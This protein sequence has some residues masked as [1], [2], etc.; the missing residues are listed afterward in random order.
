MTNSKCSLI[1]EKYPTLNAQNPFP[2]IP[3]MDNDALFSSQG[4]TLKETREQ[5]LSKKH[6]SDLDLTE[7]CKR[8]FVWLHQ[9]LY[10]VFENDGYFEFHKASKRGNNI[11][12]YQL[13][14]RIKSAEKFF[15]SPEFEY[16]LLREEQRNGFRKPT[17]V[18]NVLFV[19]LTHDTKTFL[20]DRHKAWISVE[21]YYNNFITA[22][23]KRHGK[24]WVLKSV[25]ST[26]KGYPHIHLL[27]I[28]ENSFEVF[29]HV[30]KENKESW[31]VKKK[32]KISELWYRGFIDVQ[33]PTSVSAVRRYITKD[34]L[35][36]YFNGIQTTQGEL[37]LAL[38]WLFHKRSYSISNG[39][40]F[41]DLT[42]SLSLTQTGISSQIKE[43]EKKSSSKFL[44][45]VVVWFLK[46]KPPPPTFKVRLS[47]VLLNDLYN[48]LF[49]TD[50]KMWF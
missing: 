49:H 3:L 28:C 4:I 9:P 47:R 30:N 1:V 25:E 36:Q 12:A 41:P 37:S 14:K 22:F 31:R 32:H 33:I 27:I 19:S 20:G 6:I 15:N 21:K 29:Y 44:G 17:T 35:K 16:L 50:F 2:P 5:Y 11:Y 13:N 38:N 10:L 23:R 34:M 7:L 8:F 24:C 40:M 46:G 18:S 45:C 48:H 42:N 39:K 26:E 43:I